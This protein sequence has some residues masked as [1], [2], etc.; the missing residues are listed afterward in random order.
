M[1]P[2]GIAGT[3]RLAQALGRLLRDRGQPIAA[4]AGRNPA[5]TA[6]AAAFI[7]NGVLSVSVA[8]LPLHSGRVLISVPDDALES[9]AHILAAAAQPMKVALHTCGSR[10]PEALVALETHGTSCATLHPLQT[11]ATPEQGVADLPGS[12][13]GVTGVFGTNGEGDGADWALDIVRLLGG[14]ALRI[15]PAGRPLYHAAAVMASN[16]IVTMIDAA[17]VLMGFAGVPPESALPALAPLIRASV[18]NS[19]R[20]GPAAALT[21][22]IERGD[23]RT[24]AAHVDALNGAL[25][26]ALDTPLESVRQLYG[27][28]GLHAIEVARRKSPGGDRETG[29]GEIERLLQTKFARTNS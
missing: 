25:D 9:V 27:Q 17:V 20:V 29:R 14:H 18:E 13:F 2:I 7:N 16:Y 15:A 28:A 22:P 4:I 23:V 11:I 24:V 8:E 5:R 21:G 19:L 12:F 1:E 6:S 10:G 26:G 3:G